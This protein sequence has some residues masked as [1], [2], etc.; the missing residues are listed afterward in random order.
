MI[1]VI[2]VFFF[3]SLKVFVHLTWSI[4]DSSTISSMTVINL[5]ADIGKVAWIPKDSPIIPN[6]TIIAFWVHATRIR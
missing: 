1:F 4:M 3:L 2:I 5:S 6:A